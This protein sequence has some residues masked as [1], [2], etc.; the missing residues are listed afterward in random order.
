MATDSGP[1]P[2]FDSQSPAA[3]S[4]SD[5]QE[6]ARPRKRTRRACDKCSTSRTR[7]NGEYPCRRCQDYGYTCRY[8]REVKKRGRLPASASANASAHADTV[9]HPLATY[10]SGQPSSPS[11][12]SPPDI[13]VNPPASYKPTSEPPPEQTVSPL[14]S[15]QPYEL[16]PAHDA[17]SQQRISAALNVS[18]LVHQAPAAHRYSHGTADG[19][20]KRPRL[21]LGP[22]I[23]PDGQPDPEVLVSDDS[24][25]YPSPANGQ[26]PNDYGPGYRG[27]QPRPSTSN[28]HR[29]RDSLGGAS[30]TETNYDYGTKAPTEDCSYKFLHPVLPYIRSIIPA[31]VACDLLEIFLTDPGSSLFHGASPYILTRIFRRRSILHPTHPRPTT[32]ALLATILWCVAQTADVMILHVPGTRAKIVNQL[33]ELATSLVAARD[34]DRWRRI[35]GGLRA[36]HEA[37]HPTVATASAVPTLTVANEP[38]G[39]VDDVLTYILLSIAVSGGDFKSDS[40]KWWSKATRLAFSLKMNREDERCPGPLSPC[41]NPL[42]ACRR[43]QETLTLQSLENREERRRVF[44]LLYSLDRHLSLSFNTILSIPDSYCEVFTP[45]PEYVWENLDSIPLNELP[46]RHV[47]PPTQASGTSF[48]ESFLPLMAILGD[49]IELHHR[50][51]HPRLGGLDDTHSVAV[52]SKLLADF[53]MSLESLGRE[54]RRALNEP[55]VGINGGL[56]PMDTT[57]QPRGDDSR[58]GLV[59]AYSTHILHVLH[60]LLHG[61]WDAISML[62]DGDDWI[63][64][65]RFTE[66]ASHAISASQCV[67]AILATDPELTFM[68]YLFGI[69]LLQGSFILL[70]FADRMPQLGPNESVEQACENIIR[71]HEV[72]V[73]TLNTEFQASLV[74]RKKA[75]RAPVCLPALLRV[76]H[77]LNGDAPA[78]RVLDARRIASVGGA[79][80]SS[81]RHLSS[82]TRTLAGTHGGK[83]GAE[84]AHAGVVVVTHDLAE[85]V[86]AGVLRR[87]GNF[88]RIPDTRKIEEENIPGYVS[89]RYYPTRTGQVLQ[90]RYQVVGKL[91]LRRYPLPSGWRGTCNKYCQ[92][93]GRRS[94]VRLPLDAFTIHRA[95]AWARAPV[96]YDTCAA[97]RECLQVSPPKPHPET[98]Q[99]SAC[100]HSP[101][102]LLGLGLSTH[103]LSGHPSGKIWDLFVGCFLFTGQDPELNTYRRRAHLAEIIGFLGPPPP[104]LVARGRLSYKYFADGEFQGSPLHMSTLEQRETTL[105]DAEDKADFLRFMRRMLQWGP[106]KRSSA[107]SLA[108]DDWI[109]RQL[110]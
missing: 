21:H 51:H 37:P 68:S 66:C 84:D 78:S 88:P 108:R 41:A 91:G 97:I 75:R 20:F 106:E 60:V 6:H 19:H 47:G 25:G 96:P 109:V 101:A 4:P 46:V 95:G 1:D 57:Q 48:F 92:H 77:G 40:H 27:Y 74:Q 105:D 81:G 44:W 56:P 42:C 67:S 45:L 3:P 2:D 23:G 52:I 8:N 86:D 10:A 7:C 49:I 72:C 89:A 65:K 73:V 29:H 102:C 104:D 62:D 79:S 53:E 13:T 59:K 58:V 100:M 17:R 64:S 36:E 32:P 22:V 15:A 63:T 12:L 38:A 80:S 69:Y 54:G 87:R 50:R 82:M 85:V 70:L 55:T 61:K 11:L 103:R 28:H 110:G 71:A 34:P 31:S 94:A 5:P 90:D 9:A 30:A 76:E 18:S 14:P 39:V 99:D 93:Q 98:A 26:T 16:Q 33:Y 107:K 35:H 43:E 83:L 24:A